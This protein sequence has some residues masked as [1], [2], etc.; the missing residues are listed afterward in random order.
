MGEI[1]LNWGMK[2][3]RVVVN[4]LGTQNIL[5]RGRIFFLMLVILNQQVY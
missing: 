3:E 2:N 4:S 5:N 1:S